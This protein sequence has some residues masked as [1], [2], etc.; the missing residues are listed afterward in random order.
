[1]LIK[2][3][4][5]DFSYDDT[6]F[7]KDF[8]LNLKEGIFY[9]LIG[10]N[11]S[12]KSTLTKLLL[13][14]EK[15]QVGEILFDGINIK[16]DIFALRKGVG[17]VFQNPD[18]QI[19]SDRVDEEIAFALENYGYSSEKMYEIIEELL[20]LVHLSSKKE[21]KI[22]S[23]SG[24]EKQRLC[25]ASSLALKPKLLIVDEGT[26]MLDIENR[27]RI[28]KLLRSI[29]NQGVAILLI[30]HHLDEL[31]YCDELICLEKGKLRY[32]GGKIPFISALIKGEF[33]DKIHLN[34][35]FKIAQ[36]LYKKKNL[37]ISSDIFN[38]KKVGEHLWNFL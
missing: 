27:D 19:V 23:L 33:G 6:T 20:D 1:M 25:I 7:F 34:G 2:L 5:I 35:A 29:Q 31:E 30:T 3:E 22:S 8:S 21:T 38:I 26:A 36:F 10:E 12:G 15:P 4:N 14:I 24:G 13:G 16:E 28:L 17:M 11:G 9:A 37:D 18:E 32:R